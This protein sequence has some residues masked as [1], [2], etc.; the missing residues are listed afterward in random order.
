MMH[1]ILDILTNFSIY[2][3]F[4]IVLADHKRY[5]IL[6]LGILTTDEGLKYPNNFFLTS[7][8]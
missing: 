2:Q 4:D 8:Y 7:M 6:F 3:L 5:T 1:V